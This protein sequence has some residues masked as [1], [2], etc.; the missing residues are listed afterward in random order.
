MKEAKGAT[1]MKGEKR[2]SENNFLN[3]IKKGWIAKNQKGNWRAHL[4][5]QDVAGRVRSL[6]SSR[7][8]LPT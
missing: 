4:Y 7:P 5:F 1:E 6:R 3:K 8:A 2:E